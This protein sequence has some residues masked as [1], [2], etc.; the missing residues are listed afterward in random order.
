MSSVKQRNRAGALVLLS[1]ARTN[2]L[3]AP[4]AKRCERRPVADLPEQD[5][6]QG[7]WL[8]HE[9]DFA[10]VSEDSR[11]DRRR[12]SLLATK[13]SIT[14]SAHRAGVVICSTVFGARLLN[15]GI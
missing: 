1:E 10:L 3:P 14:R 15:G 8:T 5:S 13:S 11:L 12:I 9:F 4:C 6:Q 2:N 7:T